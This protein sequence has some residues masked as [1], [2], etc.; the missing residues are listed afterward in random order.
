MSGAA[1][2]HTAPMLAAASSATTDSGTLG[3]Y[4]ATRSPGRTP[5]RVSVLASAKTW[6]A[7]SPQV[8]S[9]RGRAS[10]SNTSAVLDVQSGLD[11]RHS[12]CSA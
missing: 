5:I 2:D 7:R 8:S 12:A 3:K 4:A 1:L 6:A 10:D 11:A 9:A